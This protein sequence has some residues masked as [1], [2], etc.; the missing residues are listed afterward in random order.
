[1]KTPNSK[2]NY[3][4]GF[5]SFSLVQNNQPLIGDT[6]KLSVKKQTKKNPKQTNAFSIAAYHFSTLHTKT[7]PNKLKNVMKELIIFWG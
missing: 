1:M 4:F 5:K 3:F 2:S 6:N 7:P